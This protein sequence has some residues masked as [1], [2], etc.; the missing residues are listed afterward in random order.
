MFRWDETQTSFY[1][2]NDLWNKLI[3]EDSVY[4]LFRELAP[5]LINPDDFNNLY[6]RDNGRPSLY[7]LRMTL[8]CLVQQTARSIGSG[9]GTTNPG[10][11]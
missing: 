3:S 8:A 11:S 9:N 4:R 5:Q 6:S 7:A 1:N 10:K 2:H